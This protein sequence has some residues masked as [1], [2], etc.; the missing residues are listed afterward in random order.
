MG[1]LHSLF[2]DT[3]VVSVHVDEDGEI[4]YEE[5]LEGDSVGDVLSYVEY[6]PDD[7]IERFRKLTE[8]AVKAKRITPCERREIVA[9]YEAGLRGYTYF[10]E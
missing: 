5:E 4:D 10:E 1:E 9:D 2:G 8:H 7:C 6:K 3:H